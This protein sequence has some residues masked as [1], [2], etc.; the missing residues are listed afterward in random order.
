[1]IFCYI[2]TET[3]G[4]DRY[5]NGLVQLAGCIE[6]DGKVVEK[7]NWKMKP[8][9]EDCIFDDGAV[10][11]TGYTKDLILSSDEF[12]PPLQAFNEF[13][14][15]LEKYGDRYA[16]K[17]EERIIPIGYNVSFD[18]DF[19]IQWFKDLATSERE[20]MYGNHFF[21]FFTL[22]GLDVMQL[23]L[24]KCLRI[25]HEMQNFQLGTV[26]QTFKIGWNEEEAHDAMYDI[27]KTRQLFHVITNKKFLPQE[28]PE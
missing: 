18:T 19:L 24:L 7:F 17:G 11:K 1:M 9:K 4:M 23:A 25:K 3:T 28:V 15:M 10:K 27:K 8:V 20:R 22:P 26:C 21:N 13:F 12:I 14:T 5:R 6:K 2:D 16:K